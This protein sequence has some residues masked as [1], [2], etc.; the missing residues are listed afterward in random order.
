[1]KP[2]GRH[3]PGLVGLVALLLGALTLSACTGT[4]GEPEPTPQTT[5]PSSASP[6]P[7]PLPWGP[8]EPEVQA[9]IESAA[10]MSAEEVAGQVILGRY[11]GTDP[12]AA[13]EEL[14]RYQSSYYDLIGAN[15]FY[16]DEVHTTE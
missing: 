4:G 2:R 15:W 14:S 11:P 5:A 10:T 6:S 16:L 3:W 1:M 12:A 8:T 7:E 13:A 9:A